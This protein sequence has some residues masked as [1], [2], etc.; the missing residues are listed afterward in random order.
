MAD[1]LYFSTITSPLSTGRPDTS[2]LARQDGSKHV[3]L[4]PKL[5]QDDDSGCHNDSV[6]L[7]RI[8]RAL[9]DFRALCPSEEILEVTKCRNLVRD[10]IEMKDGDGDLSEEGVEAAFKAMEVGGM[11]FPART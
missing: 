9:R 2:G 6:L 1:I 11:I 4:P 5:P 3:I 8:W 7:Q 10:M